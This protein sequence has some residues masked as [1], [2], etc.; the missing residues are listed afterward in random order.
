[1]EFPVW[2]GYIGKMV[3]HQLVAALLAAN[4]LTL[5]VVGGFLRIKREDAEGGKPFNVPLW[6][7]LI[8]FCGPLLLVAVAALTLG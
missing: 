2:M 8:G 6:V 1:M 7:G 3:F 5:C 4:L